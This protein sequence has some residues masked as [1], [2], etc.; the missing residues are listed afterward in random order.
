MQ[1]P[2]QYASLRDNLDTQLNPAVEEILR[3]ASPVYHFRRT[4]TAPTEIHGQEIAEGDKVVMWYISANRDESVFDDPFRFD[5]TREPEEQVAFGGGGHH[6]CLG[7]NLA[8]MELQAHL[9]GGARRAS[10]TCTSSPSPRSCARTSSA[11]S[12]TWRWSTRPARGARRS[13]RSRRTGHACRGACAVA[14]GHGC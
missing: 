11:A 3:W 5:I 6:F 14:S 9:R 4:A 2:E 10:P 1:H 7:A 13:A 12:S 8:R